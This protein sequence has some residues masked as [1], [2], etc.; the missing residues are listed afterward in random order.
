MASEI[1]VNQI[2]NRGGLTITTFTDTGVTI[3]GILTVSDDLNVGGVL[4]YED[5]TNIDSVGIVTARAGINLVGNDLN[6]GSNIKIGNASG[7]VTATSFS[8][9]GANLTSLPAANLTGTLP[10]ISGANLTSLPAQA[11][12]ANNA[13]NRVITGG[14]GVN[15]NGEANLTYGG[16]NLQFTTTANGQQVLLKSTGNYYNKLSFDSGNTSAGGELAYIDFSWDGDKVAD[17][18]A[19]AGSDTTNKDDGHLVFRTSPSQGSI[20]EALRITSTGNIGINQTSPQRRLHIVTSGTAEANI[21]LQGGS[22]YAELRVKDSDN[23]F[24]I[25]TNIGGA[26]S[27]EKLKLA[28]SDATLNGTTDGVL[29]LNTT[30]SRGPFIRYQESGT[31]KCWV[32]SGQGLSLGT[33]NDLGLR[34][35]THIRMRSGSEEHGVLTSEGHF[36]AKGDAGSWVGSTSPTNTL[37]HQFCNTGNG[38]WA[39]QIQQEHHNGMCLQLRI[40][41]SGNQEAFQI[42]KYNSTASTRFRVLQNGNCANVNNSFGS[43]SD[44]SLKENIV[45]AN[46]QWNDIK[47][48]KVRN[49]NFK[50]D[51]DTKLLGV[52]AQELET[53]SPKL[54]WK[55]KEGLKGVSYSVLYMNAIKA[56][57][58]SM[59]RIETLEAEVAALKGS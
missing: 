35:T 44:V 19:E 18:F 43:L 7:I 17:I 45:D 42:Y 47:A 1:R 27:V 2:Q 39:M 48:I 15:L 57:Q 30:D 49:F 53:V 8:G 26:G 59:T 58:E 54:V 33:A 51:K 56:L 9:S 4:T 55:D 6:V 23:V 25:H 37:V 40:A 46:S 28:Q 21:R 24:S 41:G 16:G 20:A 29:N 14:S 52:V 32:G 10:A 36:A 38:R 31:T 12:I 3:S 13:D 50:D 5:V 11:T 22:D 34:A